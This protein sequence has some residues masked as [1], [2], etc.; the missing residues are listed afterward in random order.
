MTFEELDWE[1]LDRLRALFLEGQP[2]RGGYWK[3][4]RDLAC[5][6]ATFGERIGWKWDAV[7]RELQTGAASYWRPPSGPLFDFGCGSGIAG[8]R[9]LDFYGTSAF[10]G[11]YL[12]DKSRLAEEF[13]LN[14]ARRCFPTYPIERIAP[15]ALLGQGQSVTLV[16]SHVLNELPNSEVRR[17]LGLAREATTIFWLEPGTKAAS[18]ALVEVREALRDQFRIL[19]PCPHTGRC[20]LLASGREKDWCHHF[21]P[22]PPGLGTDSFWTRFARQAGIDLRS[23]PYSHLVLDRRESQRSTLS[24]GADR[25]LGRP[26]GFKGYIDMLSCSREG[27]QDLRLQRRTQPQ[28]A[29]QLEAAEGSILARWKMQDEGIVGGELLEPACIDK[30][31]E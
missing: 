28:L 20:G 22:A 2:K 9:V 25:I 23:L 1:A 5:Y 13:A 27:V 3:S 17:L 18:D 30:Q 19:R 16:V 26:I 15:E 29:Q 21:A 6:D 7:L 14:E 4:S 24:E 31:V 8:R 11:L 12:H 10:S